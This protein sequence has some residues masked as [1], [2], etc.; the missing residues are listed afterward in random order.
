MDG[1]FDAQVFSCEVGALKPDPRTYR[2]ALA[3]LDV[4]PGE[5]VFVDDVPTNVCG[6]RALG[7]DAILFRGTAPLRRELARRGLPVSEMRAAEMQ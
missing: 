4:E 7:L 6:A 2:A 1:L 5:T 3:A